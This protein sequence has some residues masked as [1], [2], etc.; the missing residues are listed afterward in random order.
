M[1]NVSVTLEQA[2]AL[3]ALARC[4]TF[5]RAAQELRRGH[6]TVLYL[7]KTLED[8]LG[9]P[10]LDRS[11]YRTRLTPRGLRMLDSCR[12]LLAAEAALASTVTELRA[13]WEPMVSVV[14]DGIVPIEPLLR[15][16]G[17]L[18][19]EKISTRF[20]VR[21]EFL[22]GVEDAFEQGRDLMIA[23]LPPRARGLVAIE[24]PPLQA[25][26]VA[27]ANHRLA[28]GRHGEQAL[29]D[30][31][32][33]TVRGSDPRLDL[34][35]ANLEPSSTVLLNDFG[36]K[37]TAILAGIGFGWLPDVLIASDLER[38][39]LRRI[40]WTRPSVHQFRPRLYHRGQ[41]GLAAKRLI[42]ALAGT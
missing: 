28:T 41:P 36:S 25:S 16:V 8:A 21:A 5:A 39:K 42:E 12:H 30:E 19:N 3:D 31:L 24:L 11:G 22:S 34:P 32:L 20:D 7:I 9:F 40:R 35:T 29:R 17:Q 23:V 14:F 15:A 4:E 18:V 27:H 26:L 1:N 37:R 6:S 10:V 33:L 2:R 13:G 38:K